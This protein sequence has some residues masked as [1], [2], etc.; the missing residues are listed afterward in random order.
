MFNNQSLTL[1]LRTISKHKRTREIEAHDVAIILS[2][3][4]CFLYSH[5]SMKKE[6]A[7]RSRWIF[8]LD[9][10]AVSRFVAVYI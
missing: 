6:K 8:N 3:S 7:R 2:A 10:A 9:G 5:L 1:I 4:F